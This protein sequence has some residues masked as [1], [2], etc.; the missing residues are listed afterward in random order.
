LGNNLAEDE[1]EASNTIHAIRGGTRKQL[2]IPMP[3]IYHTGIEQCFFLP[4]REA[5]DKTSFDL[6]LLCEANN[7]LGFRFEPAQLG[8]HDYGHIQLNR[9]MLGQTLPVEGLPDW[10]PESYPAFPLRTSDP[11]EMFLSMATSVHGYRRGMSELL[12]DVLNEPAKLKRYLDS[13]QQSMV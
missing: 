4:I 3:T 2:F 9:K 8:T 6:L 10:V 5:N 7:C 12:R 11:V 13:M 1:P